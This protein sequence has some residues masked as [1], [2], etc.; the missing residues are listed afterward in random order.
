MKVRIETVGDFKSGIGHFT[1]MSVLANELVEQLKAEV[2][3]AD[4]STD[5]DPGVDLYIVDSDTYEDT[6]GR[7]A[8]A[9]QTSPEA[10]IIVFNNGKWDDLGVDSIIHPRWSNVILHQAF[11]GPVDRSHNDGLGTILVFQGGSDPYGVAPRILNVLD[12]LFVRSQVLVVIG[13]QVHNLTMSMLQQFKQRT[14]LLA[15]NYFY[16]VGQEDMAGIMKASDVAIMPPG[17]SFAE[18]TAMHVPCILIGHHSRH[19][20]EGEKLKKK[21]AAINLGIGQLMDDEDL[22]SDI[23]NALNRM[24][25]LMVRMDYVSKANKIV[26]RHGVTAII[27]NIKK[28]MNVR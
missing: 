21:G 23:Q 16:N 5:A 28:V 13:P 11:R 6:W 9:K 2:Q 15:V 18:A 26:K 19:D 10:K 22:T 7:V 17:N 27:D 1:R 4:V 3:I 12:L 24:T 20:G 25:K 8:T 14:R